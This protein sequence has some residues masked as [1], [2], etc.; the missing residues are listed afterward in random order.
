MQCWYCGLPNQSGCLGSLCCINKGLF[1]RIAKVVHWCLR[2]EFRQSW[3]CGREFLAIHLDNLNEHFWKLRNIWRFHVVGWH[4]GAPER[5]QRGRLSECDKSSTQR[6][7]GVGV[8]FLIAMRSIGA[9]NVVLRGNIH[10]KRRMIGCCVLPAATFRR[11]DCLSAAGD[12]AFQ[13]DWCRRWLRD[14]RD[15]VSMMWR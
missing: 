10:C 13:R 15:P 9:R 11:P 14:R 8:Y 2:L 6:Y 7:I 3:L 4:K 1:C 5:G 12:P